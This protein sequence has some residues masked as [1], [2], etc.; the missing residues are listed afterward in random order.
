M[1]QFGQKGFH[2]IFNAEIRICI[3]FYLDET[4]SLT[5]STELLPCPQFSLYGTMFNKIEILIKSLQKRTL[6]IVHF[7]A[8]C[9]TRIISTSDM[10]YITNT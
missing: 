3:K 8:Y 6:Y 7:T 4:R 9:S 1:E 2:F 10:D 5:L